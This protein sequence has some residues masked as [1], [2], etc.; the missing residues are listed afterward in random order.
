MLKDDTLNHV[1]AKKWIIYSMKEKTIVKA[2]KHRYTHDIAS[3]SKLLTFYTVY[4]I[5]K[6]NFITIHN[7]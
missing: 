2:Y 4:Q 3:I 5:I 7:F 6:E 1:T